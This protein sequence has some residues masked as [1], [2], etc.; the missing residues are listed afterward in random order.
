MPTKK[1]PRDEVGAIVHAVANRVLSDPTTKNIFGNVNYAKH[2]LQGTVV[3][4]CDGC[5]PGGKNAIWKLT[6]DFK[7]PFDG[8]EVELKRVDIH[9]Q[10]CIFG[11]VPAGKNPHCSVTFTNSIGDTDHAVKG[12]STYLPNAETRESAA[13]AAAASTD[14]DDDDDNDD[15][16][17]ADAVAAAPRI[18]LSPAPLVAAPADDDIEIVLPPPPPPAKTKRKRKIDRDAATAYRPC[19]EEEQGRQKKEKNLQHCRPS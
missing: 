12:S 3:G 4:F 10:H 2:F 11:A 1:D 9:R 15:D 19:H 7:M 5:A 17:D 14:D 6:V 13:Y 18:S 16:N 8:A